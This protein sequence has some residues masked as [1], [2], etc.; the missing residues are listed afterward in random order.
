MTNEIE[1][2]RQWLEEREVAEN[3]IESYCYSMKSFFADFDEANLKNGLAWKRQL[4]DSGMKASTINLRICGF[5]CYLKF[6]EIPLTLKR[7][8]VQKTFAVENVIS[9]EEYERLLDCLQKDGKERMYWNVKLLA[10]TGARV[11]EY[12][13]LKKSDLDRGYA[14][15]WTKGKIRRIYIPEKL[16][17]A[18][19]W[20]EFP[21]DK[22]LATN[23]LGK[24]LS[25][26]GVDWELKQC[27]RIYG[28]DPKKMHP[29]AFRHLFA[30][31]FLKQTKDISLLADVL[32]H[33]SVSTTAIYTRMTQEQQSTAINNAV[34][35]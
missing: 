13:R 4:M 24:P 27:A 29:H 22:A 6:K 26:R 10:M 15:L 1:Q 31:E 23:K 9:R 20:Q 12:I 30:L 34:N 14:E 28:I 7:F 5:N 18:H 32:G 35:W 2:F 16:Q 8:K 17:E 33:S 21:D 11:S 19:Y 3:T 25:T